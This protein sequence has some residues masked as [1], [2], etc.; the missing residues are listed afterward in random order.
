MKLTHINL[1]NEQV[2]GLNLGTKYTMEL[3]PTD[4]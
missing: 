1:T 4:T 2:N 3:N